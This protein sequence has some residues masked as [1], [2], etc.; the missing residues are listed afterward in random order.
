[1]QVS[2]KVLAAGLAL[3]GLASCQTVQEGPAESAFGMAEGLACSQ[4]QLEAADPGCL[5]LTDPRASDSS[6]RAG[7]IAETLLAAGYRPVK[8]W[9]VPAR[10]GERVLG[11]VEV[12]NRGPCFRR[13]DCG[14][15]FDYYVAAAIPG[16]D[17]QLLVIDPAVLK[18]PADMASWASRLVL[19]GKSLADVRT[20]TAGLDVAPAG[21]APDGAIR[22]AST[23][24]NPPAAGLKAAYCQLADADEVFSGHQA[25]RGYRRPRARA[26][27]CPA[28]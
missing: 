28:A 19:G 27:S 25:L 20:G 15:G 21:V 7:L 3:I 4:A 1:M 13:R 17:G 12:Q 11:F 10:A 6:D 5:V 24:L 8:V 14:D 9:A 2:L 26:A 18:G 22:F 23:V 16:P